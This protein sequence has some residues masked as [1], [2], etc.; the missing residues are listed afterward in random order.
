MSRIVHLSDLHFGAV[1]PGMAQHLLRKLHLLSPDLTVISGDLTQN[2][3]S[4]EFA[5]AAAFI[6]E[7][8]QPCLVVP[9]N[10]DMSS[11]RLH[12]RFFYP[13]QKWQQY[14]STDLEPVIRVPGVIAVGL[15]TCRRMS[16]YLDWSR[17]RINLRQL[18]KI[19]T[20]LAASTADEVRIVVTHHPFYLTEASKHRGLIGRLE[21]AWP[22]MQAAGVDLVLSGHIHLAYAQ[23]FHGMI[24]AHAGSGISHRLRGEAN[25][26]NLITA[27]RNTIEIQQMAWREDGFVNGVQQCF[28][29]MEQGFIE[30]ACGIGRELKA[31]SGRV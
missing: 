28:V 30:S 27:S 21:L 17:G 19:E 20:E 13:W 5:E 14:I 8:P 2:A 9:G 26:F 1:T 16:V 22:R 31:E 7:L 3:R 25:S 24:V 29:R 4:R 6:A 23:V 18:A 11:L 10:H 15:N 12:E